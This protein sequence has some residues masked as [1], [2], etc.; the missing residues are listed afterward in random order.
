MART[1][2]VDIPNASVGVAG[3]STE[4]VSPSCVGLSLAPS[5]EGATADA[6]QNRNAI[7]TTAIGINHLT[8]VRRGAL[9][10]RRAALMVSRTGGC[11]EGVALGGATVA[12]DVAGNAPGR[13]P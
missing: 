13:R 9:E 10:V 2:S 4:L 7:A 12:V 11:G 3:A 1:F 5:D 8:F 6:P